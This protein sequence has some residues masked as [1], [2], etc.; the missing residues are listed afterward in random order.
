MRPVAEVVDEIVQV[1]EADTGSRGR[2]STTRD[3]IN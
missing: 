1:V 2:E 3:H